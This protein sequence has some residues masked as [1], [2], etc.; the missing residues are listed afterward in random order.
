MRSQNST[1]VEF[2]PTFEL[3]CYFIVGRTIRCGQAK[4]Q[5]LDLNKSI[6][7]LTFT[8][9]NG[10]DSSKVQYLASIIILVSA[11]LQTQIYARD[12]RE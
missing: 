11:D 7:C 9:S 10:D 6:I 1:N 2:Y 8:L 4:E 5:L 3:I 12:I